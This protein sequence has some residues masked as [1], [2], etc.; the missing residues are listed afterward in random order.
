M[1][2]RQRGE[3]E[4]GILEILWSSDEPLTAVDVRDRFDEPIPATTTIITVL[5][6]LRS[7]GR[8]QREK[9]GTGSY[10][11]STTADHHEHIAESM[12]AALAA[13]SDR[14]LALMNFTGQLTDDDRDALRRMLDNRE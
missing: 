1:V 12:A 11:Y 10:R 7:K 2:Q 4:H 13:S 3:L 6:R 14:S 9:S 5:D 8:V